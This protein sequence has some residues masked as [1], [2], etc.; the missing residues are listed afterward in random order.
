MRRTPH[1][2]RFGTALAAA[3]RA[4]AAAERAEVSAFQAESASAG[5]GWEPDAPGDADAAPEPVRIGD[6]VLYNRATSDDDWLPM[7]VTHVIDADTVDGI[8]FSARP[9][10]AG[11]DSERP[12]VIRLDCHR[13]T[14]Y[15]DWQP[16]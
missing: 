7:L 3:L 10:A 9:R 2:L 12:Y 14:E 5:V 4:E 16:R 13:G 15:R 6:T 8:V 11:F 1:R